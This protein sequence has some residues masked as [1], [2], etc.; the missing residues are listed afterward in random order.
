TVLITLSDD[1]TDLVQKLEKEYNVEIPNSEAVNFVYVEDILNYLQENASGA[2]SWG[3]KAYVNGG[4]IEPW[5]DPGTG[6]YFNMGY[7]V[8]AGV[9]VRLGEY[10]D[11]PFFLDPLSIEVVGNYSAFTGKDWA[12]GST[13]IIS[14]TVNGRY[15]VTDLLFNA[16][17]M[18]PIIGVFGLVGLQYNYHQFD[19]PTDSN[20]WDATS[21]FGSNLGVGVKYG[22]TDEVGL[23]LRFTQGLYYIS[24]VVGY[25]SHLENGFLLGVT[26]KIQ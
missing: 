16:L 10:V 13:S 6:K 4:A 20:N 7:H 17:G 19:G 9:L 8:G 24:D 26:F 11:V 22:I 1:M 21:S 25:E 2:E 18:E 12:G 5:G 14:G 15:D 23:D 3:I